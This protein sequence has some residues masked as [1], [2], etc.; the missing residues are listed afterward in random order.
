M[1]SLRV[2]MP[3][4]EEKCHRTDYWARHH[5]TSKYF[6]N[7]QEL[8]MLNRNK[9]FNIVYSIWK[10]Y[11]QTNKCNNNFH[12]NTGIFSKIN[13]KQGFWRDKHRY[14]QAKKGYFSRDTGIFSSLVGWE[15]ISESL[16]Q[17]QKKFAAN[18]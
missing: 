5:V 18:G 2:A 3:I 7:Q 10:V 6:H 8:E 11:M 17:G 9:G 1:L 16:K 15:I 4:P 14:W 13:K 12:Q